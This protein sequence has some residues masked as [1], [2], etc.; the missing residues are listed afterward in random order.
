MKRLLSPTQPYNTKDN[1]VHG[2]HL[3]A[4][5]IASFRDEWKA[6]QQ[7]CKSGIAPS[8]ANA[9]RIGCCLDNHRVASAKSTRL[10]I[11]PFAA[12]NRR[13]S[14]PRHATDRFKKPDIALGSL[15]TSAE[16]RRY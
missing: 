8:L 1:H 9:L 3:I 15:S 16:N 5:G 11:A 7:E 10:M 4:D 13:P 6:A 12:S 14:G 2:N